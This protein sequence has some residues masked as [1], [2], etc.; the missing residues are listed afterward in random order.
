MLCLNELRQPAYGDTSTTVVHVVHIKEKHFTLGLCLDS[1]CL[2]DNIQLLLHILQGFHQL[3]LKSNIF[4][5]GAAAKKGSQKS[6]HVDT[7]PYSLFNL[8]SVH[9][10]TL[11][12]LLE[13]HLKGLTM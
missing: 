8:T 13:F 4:Q 5:L 6:C 11:F 2:K 9:G 3:L 12:V 1:Y 10:L 7:G